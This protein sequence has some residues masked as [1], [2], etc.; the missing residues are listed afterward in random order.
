MIRRW[1]L[2]TVLATCLAAIAIGVLGIGLSLR[3]SSHAAQAVPRQP[4]SHVSLLPAP[5]DS[6]ANGPTSSTDALIRKYQADARRNPTTPTSYTNLA[7]AYMQKERETADVSYYT[8]TEDAARA[9][10]RLDPKN[11]AAV[12]YEAWVA[13]GRHDFRSAARY[14]EEAIQLNRYASAGYGT[15]GDAEANLGDYAAMVKAYQRMIDLKPSL[16]A[17]NR[18]SYARWLFGDIRGAT[19]FMLLAIR[20]GSTQPENVAWCE[21]QLGDDYFNAGFLLGAEYEYK[22]ALRTFPHYARALAGM[23]TVEFSLGHTAA[24]VRYYKQAIAVVPLP[25]YVI[26][27]GDIYTKLGEARAAK[28]QYALIGYINHI[29]AINHVRYGIETAQYDADHNQDLANAL[30]IARSE[31]QHRHDIQTMDTLAWVL[32]KNGR[33]AEAWKA[34]KQALRLHT[35]FAPLYFHAGMIQAKLGN[36]I[37]AQ[38]YLHSA[39]MLNPNF[40]PIFASVARDELLRL[41]HQATTSSSDRQTRG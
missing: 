32:Y 23:A 30:R 2:L 15:L 17:Y 38:S 36:L 8:L 31:A 40:H 6:A 18:A 1:Q 28:K 22:V 27:L 26:G 37:E 7:L 34:E 9:A 25:Q 21:S 16:A 24:A 3:P 41:N 39:L 13:L 12:S 14:A 4:A 10:L 29:F 20:A 35:H 19:R 5:G 33:Y 11:Y